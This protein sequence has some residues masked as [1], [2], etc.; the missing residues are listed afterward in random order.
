M[1]FSVLNPPVCLEAFLTIPKILNIVHPFHH[2]LDF[3]PPTWLSPPQSSLQV[4]Y[5]I[6]V[7]S[8][9]AGTQNQTKPHKQNNTKAQKTVHCTL[10][11]KVVKGSI[12][13]YFNM[14]NHLIMY[15]HHNL[16]YSLVRPVPPYFMC[17]GL[18]ISYLNL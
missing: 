5:C 10:G 17:T 14:N 4:D 13:Q 12:I 9:Y 3:L 16:T 15:T 18:D 2:L 11:Q 7:L 8:K 6:G 1:E